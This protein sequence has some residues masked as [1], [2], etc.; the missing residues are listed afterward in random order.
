MLDDDVRFELWFH[1]IALPTVVAIATVLAVRLSEARSEI[2]NYAR[3]YNTCN[4]VLT[5]LKK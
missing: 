1:R 2:S 3:E 4:Q 5:E